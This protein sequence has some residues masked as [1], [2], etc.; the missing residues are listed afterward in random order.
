M[1][2][3]LFA[4][5]IGL[6]AIG[7]AAAQLSRQSGTDTAGG[8]ASAV[9][10]DARGGTEVAPPVVAAD[11]GTTAGSRPAPR[12][13]ATA[14]TDG[15]ALYIGDPPG[16]LSASADGGGAPDGGNAGAA[17]AGSRGATGADAGSQAAGNTDEV[18]RLRERVAALEQELARYRSSTVAQS[19]Q[20]EQLNQLNQQV[21]SLREQLAQE[22]ARRQ[23]EENASR[24]AAAQ[25]QQAVTALSAAQQQL[26]AGDSRVMETLQSAASSLPPPAQRAVESARTAVQSGDLSMARYWLSVA[27]TQTQQ[28]E[29]KR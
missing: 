14:R 6:G 23:T 28:A 3:G 17:D 20:V 19:Q 16:R 12:S 10:A 21:A 5:V 26:A 25:Q 24:Q 4:G 1:M 18:Q 27:I 9:S 29:I 13:R 8:S 22:Q 7:V 2:K 11:A 15:G